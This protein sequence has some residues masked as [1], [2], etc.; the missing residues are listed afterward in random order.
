MNAMALENAAVMKTARNATA[1]ESRAA[2]CA[3]G[4]NV[5]TSVAE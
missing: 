3:S 1:Y 2:L 4:G 5:A